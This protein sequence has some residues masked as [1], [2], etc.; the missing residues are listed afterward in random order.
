MSQQKKG[1]Q[2][3]KIYEAWLA[4]AE[5]VSNASSDQQVLKPHL[6]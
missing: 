5:K 6:Q 3:D 4:N 1:N 2:A